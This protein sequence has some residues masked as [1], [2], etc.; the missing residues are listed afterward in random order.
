MRLMPI[1]IAPLSAA[2]FAVALIPSSALAAPSAASQCA[3]TIGSA[4][5]DFATAKHDA[6]VDC[7]NA[8]LSGRHCNESKRDRQIA[9]ALAKME[10]E[11]GRDCRGVNLSDLGFP[12]SCPNP[13]GPD[14]TVD[15]LAAC[16]ADQVEAQVDAAIAAEFPALNPL[17]GDDEQCAR[18]IARQGQI[19]LERTFRARTRCFELQLEGR[20]SNAINCRAEPP[21]GDDDT[22]RLIAKATA[23]LT[24]KIRRGCKGASLTAIGFPGSACLTVRGNGFSVSELTQCILTTHEGVADAIINIEYPLGAGPTPTATSETTAS[25]SPSST[26]SAT[27]GEATATETATSTPGEPTPTETATSTPG[28]PTPTETVTSTPGEPTP[29]E[30]VTSTPGEATPTATVTSTP[31]EATPTAT[32]T[33]T[34]GEATPTAT[35][36]STPGEPTATATATSTPGEPTATATATS[37]PGEPTAT[38]TATTTPVEPTPT[39]TAT[40]TP[41]PTATTFCEPGSSTCANAGNGLEIC[42]MEGTCECPARLDFEGDASDPATDL[43]TGWTGIAHDSRIV[44]AGKVTVEITGCDNPNR[45]NP[46]HACG[47]C[48]FTGPIP[49]PAPDAGDIDN[50]RCKN[51]SSV[52]CTSNADCTGAGNACI[53]YFGGPLPLSAG[54]VATCVTN[55]IV[56]AIIGTANIETGETASTLESHLAAS[57]PAS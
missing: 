48:D 43:D 41:T 10:R 2:A 50:Q 15:E 11:I 56:G 46:E 42:S 17:S 12:G 27:A 49:N 36:T 3:A 30:T 52:K 51:D 39:E 26:P 6:I 21:T 53:F 57:S 24:D 29:T 13:G 35:V 5:A 54:G 44:S 22:D 45:D 8:L 23:R 40:P 18:T 20:I 33:S 25:P 14:F 16:F 9:R 1:W 55:E 31:G 28:E 19:F 7:D 34:P 38:E 37:T 4:G 47:I 32:V